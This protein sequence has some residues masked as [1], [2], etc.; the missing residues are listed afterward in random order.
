MFDQTSRVFPA[1]F[2][3]KQKYIYYSCIFLRADIILDIITVN[4]KAS[5]GQKSM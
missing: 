5:L 1:G 4:H 2:Q 3:K